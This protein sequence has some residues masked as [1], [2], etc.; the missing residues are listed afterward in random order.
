MGYGLFGLIT[1]SECVE[2]IWGEDISEESSVSSLSWLEQQGMLAF[3]SLA[4]RT[5]LI[6][7][8]WCL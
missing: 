7:N 3:W 4:S 5:G 6:G 2:P 8:G 1:V